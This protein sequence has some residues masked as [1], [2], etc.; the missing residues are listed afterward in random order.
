MNLH[1]VPVQTDT[2]RSTGEAVYNKVVVMDVDAGISITTIN[3]RML[4]DANDPRIYAK[5]AH[6]E[7]LDVAVR[8]TEGYV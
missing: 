4:Y 8:I 6:G 2:D 3:L 1:L 5:L 7:S